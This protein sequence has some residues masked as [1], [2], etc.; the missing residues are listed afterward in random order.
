M[1]TPTISSYHDA[2][3]S[4]SSPYSSSAPPA[5]STSNSS[6]WTASSASSSVLDFPQH[7]VADS[8]SSASADLDDQHRMCEELL[9]QLERER[10]LVARK[11]ALHAKEM[12]RR[13]AK[14]NNQASST[15]EDVF[16]TFG[17]VPTNGAG[18]QCLP[19]SQALPSLPAAV[20]P[21]S[22]LASMNS[23]STIRPSS[24]LLPEPERA[25][26]RPSFTKT[27][28]VDL[29]IDAILESYSSYYDDAYS[30][31]PS[32]PAPEPVDLPSTPAKRT[33]P[34]SKSSANLRNP[35]IRHDIFPSP[36][37]ASPNAAQAFGGRPSLTR[38]LTSG[39]NPSV[40]SFATTNSADNAYGELFPHRRVAP[41][42]TLKSKKSTT[43]VRSVR[44]AASS[45]QGVFD[46]STAPPLPSGPLPPTPPSIRS[47]TRP[48]SSSYRTFSSFARQST[49]S[50][51]SAQS[52]GSASTPPLASSPP[53]AFPRGSY[54]SS[55]TASSS[56]GGSHRWSVA[57]SSTAPSSAAFSDAGDG[58]SKR[59]SVLFSS[60]PLGVPPSPIRR[61]AA[62]LGLANETTEEEADEEYEGLAMSGASW[63]KKGLNRNSIQSSSIRGGG[64]ALLS[65][66]DFASELD[67]LPPPPK[68][69]PRPFS[70]S[71]PRQ[72]SIVSV[73]SMA[74]PPRPASPAVSVNS[75]P[76]NKKSTLKSKLSL[77]T[78]RGR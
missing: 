24:H 43:S 59:G 39:S 9:E 15:K 28:L 14:R 58:C 57:T 77:A 35:N 25:P 36:P 41:F 46:A 4:Y 23:M 56:C 5:A 40:R 7:L 70:S 74:F 1:S 48:S 65:W 11:N 29:D 10:D 12:A 53:L 45:S 2:P 50:T 21:S 19:P 8:A 13:A 72:A 33:M 37:V 3:S 68:V 78:L 26:R 67:A 6:L 61:G 60:P 73:S 27:D 32:S 16:G 20:V 42:P 64:G 38:T 51:S 55:S 44:N 76:V 18:P 47:S 66:E 34:R 49:C 22:S 62:R 30:V 75:V 52:Y 63:A 17:A 69:R 71:R 31:S 54:S